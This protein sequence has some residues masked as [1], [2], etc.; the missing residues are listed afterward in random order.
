[1]RRHLY[2]LA[3]SYRRTLSIAKDKAIAKFRSA[4][5][6]IF[7]EFSPPPGGGGHQ[8]LR[9]V[10]GEFERRGLRVENN[11]IS[12]TTRACLYNSFNFDFDRLQQL[13]REGCRM[14]HRV[15]G[16]IGVYRGLDDGSDRYIWQINQELADATIFQS[17][18]SLHK[19]LELGLKF[20]SPSVIMNATNPPIFHPH[21]RIAFDRNRKIRLI[22]TSWS[23]NPNKGASA[24]K[25]LEEHLDWERFEYTF[26]GRSPIQFD[27]I[28]MLPPVLPEH[29][30]EL[31]RQH[32]IYITASR[33]ECCSN[34]L[35]EA[36]S[37]GLPAIYVKSG[38]NAE[39]VGKAGFGFESPE[40]IPALLNQLVDEYEYRQGQIAI[41]TIEE[42]VDRYL[43]IMG[44]N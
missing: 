23:D 18:Y 22:S 16:P 12:A 27:Q 41:P 3:T 33:H 10:W 43:A 5:V 24:Y 39:I 42:V 44:F 9:T 15:D 19:H 7:H 29:L 34:S 32:D 6:S 17:Q 37:C 4:D 11:T 20:K 26:V 8:F 13:H 38:S 40:E 35:L 31:R 2:G 1:M 28:Q 30:A 14:V 25:W 21:G 36:L